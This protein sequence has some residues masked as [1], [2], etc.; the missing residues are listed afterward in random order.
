MNF[1]SR[2]NK[3]IANAFPP[4]A[5]LVPN[6]VGLDISSQ[7]VRYVELHKKNSTFI[8]KSIGEKKIKE[9]VNMTEN[10]FAD[11]NLKEVL[12]EIKK[13]CNFDNVHVSLP[14][15]KAY[16]FKTSVP[17]MSH[18]EIR[19]HLE[20]E[21]EENVPLHADEVIFD[22]SVS[23]HDGENQNHIEVVVSAFP[24]KVVMSYVRLLEEEGFGVG[25]LH[26]SAEA[27]TKAVVPTNSKKTHLVVNFGDKKTGIYITHQQSV[28]FSSTLNFGGDALTT[29]IAKHF[30]VDIHKAIEIKKDSKFMKDKEMM[31][32]FF[33]LMNPISSLRE[34][35]NRL[36]TYWNTHKDHDDETRSKIDEIILCGGDSLLKGLDEYLS[37]ELGLPVRVANVWQNVPWSESYLPEISFD[38]SLDYAAAVGL[39]IGANL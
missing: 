32:L 39:A 15:E 31:A 29:G 1:I 38:R 6:A 36:S 21:I 26:I 33:A 7:S 11:E 34:E 18:D 23:P 10:I 5:Y 30:G 9:N 28:L 17:I 37:N 27:V 8:L 4:P 16:L 19:A 35:I 25:G 24:K 22:F 12:R 13:E 2:L 14:D 3:N 20:L